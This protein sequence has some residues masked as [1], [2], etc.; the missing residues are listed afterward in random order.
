M[1]G[2]HFEEQKSLSVFVKDFNSAY[3]LQRCVAYINTRMNYCWEMSAR[4]H[5]GDDFEERRPLSVFVKDFNS[6]YHLPHALAIPAMS[7][8][9]TGRREPLCIVEKDSKIDAHYRSLLK[10][11]TA[12]TTCHG[13]LSISALSSFIAGRKAPVCT[14]KII[15]KNDGP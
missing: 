5:S 1:V 4:L 2:E 15:L 10:I 9:I 6:A 12:P 13:A 14:V 11:L 7:S 3:H 8:L